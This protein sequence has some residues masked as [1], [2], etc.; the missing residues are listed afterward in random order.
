MTQA[1]LT[2]AFVS[3]P[4]LFLPSLRAMDAALRQAPGGLQVLFLGA[5][6]TPQM[7]DWVAQV[8]AKHPQSHIRTEVLPAEWL[9]DARSPKDFITSTALGAYVFA[10]ADDGA[11]AV[12]GWRHHGDG[13]SVKG[14]WH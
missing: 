13:R 8:A 4:G 9:A 2:I 5:N 3:D 10:T 7:W 1:P 12:S 14:R 11:G 6:L